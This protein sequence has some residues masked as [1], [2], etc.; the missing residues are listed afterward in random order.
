MGCGVSSGWNARLRVPVSDESRRALWLQAVGYVES[1]R[2][3]PPQC[4]R[5]GPEGQR[6]GKEPTA[7]PLTKEILKVFNKR[8]GS[9][10]RTWEKV[11][12]WMKEVGM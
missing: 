10:V 4:E 8:K 7:E 12:S 5:G 3:A 2:P 9:K 11:D 1:C 6:E